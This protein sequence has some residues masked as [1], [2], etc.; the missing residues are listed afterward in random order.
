MTTWVRR[1]RFR[2]VAAVLPLAGALLLALVS[3]P[4]GATPDGF[5]DA[6]DVPLALD[7]KAVSH[8]ND[9]R[10]VTYTVE[11]WQSFPDQQ[12][13]LRW[14]LVRSGAG[15]PGLFVSAR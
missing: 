10:S 7:L 1:A 4:S 5:T 14:A 12:A 2:R 8:T 13:N 9:E 11:T 3:L 6:D 15:A